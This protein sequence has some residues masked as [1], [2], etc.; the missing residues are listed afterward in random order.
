MARPK[1]GRPHTGSVEKLP[2][3]RY[4]V[5]FTG[6]DGGRH[7]APVTFEDVKAARLWLDRELRAI[8]DDPEGWEA[9]DVRAA[10]RK[11]MA[12]TFGEYAE[13][14][15]AGRKV[16]GRPLADR[17]RDHYRDLLD[18]F[19][20]PTFG[21][22]ALVG[23][24]PEQVDRWYE[25]TAADTPTYRAHAYALLRTILG[26]AVDRGL[27]R[28]AN[29]AKV[30]GG[31]TTKRAKKIRP[32]TL[33]ELAVIASA[34][35]ERRRV[36]V[37]LAAWTALR[38]G[39]LAE[40]RRGDVDL[41][42]GVIHV[43]RGVV[44]VRETAPD[45][46]VTIVQKVKTP[47]TDAGIRDVP[48][49]PHLIDDV[50]AHL[51]NHAL[52]GKDGLLFPGQVDRDNEGK[53]TKVSH[54]SSSAFYGRESLLNHDGSIKRKGHGYFE[55]RRIAGRPDL[56]F[57]ALRHTG[58]TNA[59]VAGATLAELM[60]L[61]GHSTSGAAMRYQHAAQDRMQELAKRMSELAGG[62]P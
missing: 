29:P 25:L 30:R 4:R 57:H 28:T 23:I 27:I 31:G 55:A 54:L 62:Q 52:P 46:T 45:G 49:P 18:R 20:L 58:L 7:K 56:N 44:R 6:P 50:R 43:R 35:P 61:A 22:D 40:L 33:E 15:L 60:A 41:K 26:T 11:A 1:T 19:L 12:L 9:P 16:R 48:I 59:A 47:K 2:S 36:M 3:G 21:D 10:S 53:A 24:T 13:S 38:F 51:E 34:M 37:V 5:R 39:E 42:R 8:E 17:T 14:W 32:A